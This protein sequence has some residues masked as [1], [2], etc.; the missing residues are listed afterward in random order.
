MPTRLAAPPRGEPNPPMPAPQV[1]ARRMG[2]ASLD[3]CISF[4]PTNFNIETAT[5]NMMVQ[6]TALG[7]KIERMVEA[8]SQTR[9]CCFKEG[10]MRHNVLRDNLLSRPVTVQVKQIKSAP[11]RSTM[12]SEKYWE[13]TPPMGTRL[14]KA[15]TTMGSS[16]V[17]EIC[18][19]VVI[20]HKPIQTMVLKAAA[21]VKPNKF[22]PARRMKANAA[23]PAMTA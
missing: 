21:C 2:T 20:H 18:T 22:C 16:A 14:K 12:I 1:I 6:T 23:G 19:G 7:R 10:P 17:T 8:K 15:L 3:V 11:K 13:T 5:G 4:S 9:I